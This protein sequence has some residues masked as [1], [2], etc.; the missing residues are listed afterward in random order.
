[1]KLQPLGGRIIVSPLKKEESSIIIPES[2]L[3]E[4]PEEGTV[5]AISDEV[6][7]VNVG[8]V[9]LFKKFS[10]DEVKSEGETYLILSV[11]DLLARVA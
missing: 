6:T 10:P 7:A 1:M 2:V 8:D 9:V 5:V 4:R 3:R 11:E